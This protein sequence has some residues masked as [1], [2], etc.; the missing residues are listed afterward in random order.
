MPLTA[1]NGATVNGQKQKHVEVSTARK[2]VESMRCAEK[3]EDTSCSF[4]T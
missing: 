4:I 3:E 1:I 2:G